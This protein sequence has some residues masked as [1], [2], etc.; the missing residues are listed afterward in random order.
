MKPDGLESWLGEHRS[1]HDSR[2]GRCVTCSVGGRIGPTASMDSV[3]CESLDGREPPPGRPSAPACQEPPSSWRHSYIRAT[4]RCGLRPSSIAARTGATPALSRA[5]PRVPERGRLGWL[6]DGQ[7]VGG[8]TMG[9]SPEAV[10]MSAE[11]LERIHPVMHSY[12]DDRGFGGLNAADRPARSNGLLGTVRV[13]GQRGGHAD[14]RGHDLPDL[15]DDEADRQHGAD[16][17][18]RGRSH[19]AHRPSGEVHPSLRRREGDGR[20]RIAGRSHP[21]CDGA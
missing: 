2:A 1:G 15:F 16:D 5:P 19:P 9:A 13:P 10:G 20:R 12:I 21:S 17:A 8:T 4:R 18:V 3:G 6:A 7:R 14:D 11:R